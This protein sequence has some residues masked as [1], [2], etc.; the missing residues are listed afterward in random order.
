MFV[1][2]VIVAIV[3]RDLKL[4]L[5]CDISHVRLGDYGVELRVLCEQ[6]IVEYSSILVLRFVW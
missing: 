3:C 6:L 2:G 1:V 5:R 4:Y